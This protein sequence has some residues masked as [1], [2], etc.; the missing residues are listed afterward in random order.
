MKEIHHNSGTTVFIS[1]EEENSP[2]EVWGKAG[3]YPF[4]DGDERT[5]ILTDIYPDNNGFLGYAGNESEISYHVKEIN[6]SIENVKEMMYEFDE[7]DKVYIDASTMDDF[8]KTLLLDNV[9]LSDYITSNPKEA[10]IKLSGPICTPDSFKQ[11]VEELEQKQVKLL[12]ERKVNSA[13]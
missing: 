1:V 12:A 9:N 11:F 7:N 5:G 10:T 13:V 8:S 3:K 2:Y 6:Q 4:K